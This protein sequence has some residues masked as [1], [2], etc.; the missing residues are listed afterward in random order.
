MGGTNVP[1]FLEEHDE[2]VAGMVLIDLSPEPPPIDRIPPAA[3]AEFERNT[4]A[5]EGLDLQTL[6]AGFEE[7]RASTRSLGSK[8]LA[9]LVAGRA[10]E[11]PNVDDAQAKQVLAERQQAQSRL[12]PLSTNSVLVIA[13]NSSHH[14]P[15]EDPKIVNRAVRAVVE[16]ARTGRALSAA[17]IQDSVQAR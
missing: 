15:D 12:L 10:L 13:E 7:L 3:M 6:I 16:S 17:E 11:D 1:L 2:S 5:L 9:I 4:A 8:P 14:I